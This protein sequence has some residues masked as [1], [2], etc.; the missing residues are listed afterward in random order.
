MI[1]QKELL[2]SLEINSRQTAI[3]YEGKEIS[4]SSLLSD[5]NRITQFLLSKQLEEETVIGV[6]LRDKS[7]LIC[8]II[9]IVNARC[10]FVLLDRS[11]P[12]S[13]MD[14]LIND[15]GLQ[16]VISAKDTHASLATAKLLGRWDYDE[17]QKI[18]Q[19]SDEWAY[20]KAEEGDSLY[21]YFTSG[22]TGTPKGI[23]G[24]NCSLLQFLQWEIDEFGIDGDSR[25]SQFISPYFD[26]FLRDIFV[27]LLAGGTICIPP[28]EED[29]FSSDKIIP[30]IDNSRIS[31][32]HC[33]P[34][35]FRI[36]NNN[37]L[38][39]GNFENLKHVLLSGEKINP[40]E[41]A[42]WYDVFGE[43]TQLANFYGATEATMIR[44]CYKIGPEDVKRSRM[45]IGSPIAATKLLI[46]RQNMEP[47]STLVPGDLYIIS[48]YLTKGYLNLP[49]LTSE[50]FIKIN[51]GTPEETVAYKTGD[52][53]RKLA[54][55]QIELLGREDRQV[56][57]RG[58]R[59]ELDEVEVILMKS[60][61]LQ[62]AVVILHTEEKG[63]ESLVAFLIKKDGGEEK[64][65]LQE[66]ISKYLESHVS[67]YMIP[68]NIVFVEEYPLLPNGK[69]NFK[70][71]LNYLT[72]EKEIV[73]PV[74]GTEEK[75]LSIWKEILGERNISTE[76]SFHKIGGN[77]LSLMSLIARV[78]KEFKIRISLSELFKNPTIQKQAL[79]IQNAT[80]KDES[81]AI[82][83]AV[84]AD[85]YVLS[86]SQKRLFFLYKFDPT[87]LAY[88]MPNVFKLEGELSKEHIQSVFKKLISRH[89]S[90][91]TS[92]EVID[93]EPVQRIAEQVDFEVEC[94]SSNEK[95][96][97]AIIQQ[98][99]RPFDLSSPSLIRVGLIETALNE[100]QLMVDLHHIISDGVSQELL[101]KEFMALYNGGQLPESKLNYKDFATWQQGEAQQKGVVQQSK[102]WHEEFSEEV[103]MLDLPT[104][105]VRPSI[106]SY[107]G[108]SLSFEISK[109]ETSKIESIAEREGAT[110]FMV[111]LSAYYI[112]MAKL[113][114]QEDIVVGTPIAGRHQ[115]ELENMFGMFV[116]TLSLRNHPEGNLSYKAFLS[117]VKSKTLSCLD[118]QD[119]PYEE[120]IE[121]LKVE[122]DTSRNPLFD[123]MFSYQNYKE[124]KLEIPELTLSQLSNDQTIS[125]FD[126]TLFVFEKQGKL[127]L[128]F[129][130][131]T[132]LFKKETVEKLIGYFKKIVSAITTDLNTKISDIEIV[133]DHE[134]TQLLTDFNNTE[135]AFDTELTI[136][137]IFEKTAFEHG[138]KTALAFKGEKLSYAEL[139]E[140]SNQ[141]AHKLKKQLQKEDKFIGI[142]MERSL[143]LIVSML[144]VLKSG[145]AY[146][147][148]DPE[149]PISRIQ[150]IAKDSQLGIIL[151]TPATQKICDQLPE[152]VVSINV[153]S[154][155]LRLEAKVP[156]HHRFSSSNLAYLIYT[157]GSTGTPKGVMV[158]HRNVIN[159]MHGIIERIA[160]GKVNS[161]LSLTTSSFDIFVLESIVPLLNGQKIVLASAEEQK[162]T[163]ALY[164]LIK[165]QKT[166]SIQIT[167]SHLKLLL[168]GSHSDVLDDVKVLMVGGEAFPQGLLK[169]VQAC[170]SGKI[171][172]MYGPTE[173][174]VWSSIKD[175][176]GAESINIGTP[177]ANT[178][179]RI[180]DG[181]RRLQAVGI[182]GELYIGGEGVTQGYW[183]NEE[184][185]RERF[186]KDPVTGEGTIYQT[187]DRARWLPDGNI[188]FLGR[189]DNQVKIS[190]HRIELGE[191]ESE[192]SAHDQIEE[193]VIV[194]KEKGEN[195]FLT[196]YYLSE[197][198]LGV[199]E[200]REFLKDRLPV[201]MLP[202]F[203][204]HLDSFPLTPNGKLDKRALP[205]PEIK[206]GDEFTAPSNETEEKL[207][208]LWSETLAIQKES[209]SVDSSFFE[210]G[211]HSI[212]AIKLIGLIQDS[213]GVNLGL[214]AF[215]KDPSIK[216]ISKKI[217]QGSVGKETL[218]EMSID[219][220]HR[221]DPFPLTDVQQAYLIGR[222]DVFEYGN[223][224]TH[225]YSESFLTELDIDGFNKILQRLIDRHEMLRMVITADGEQRILQEVP[226]YEVK[227]LD[228]KEW[229]E[230]EGEELFYEQRNELSHQVF[231]GEEWPLFDIRVT[232]FRDDT[233]K[234]HYSV[235]ALMID[236]GSSIIL[237]N[238]FAEL[239]R[240]VDVELSPVPI[241]FRDYVQ[242]QVGLRD[243]SLFE[244]SQ[245]YWLS[246]VEEMPFAPDLPLVS[247]EDQQAKPNFE[248]HASHLGKTNWDKLQG[249]AK[250]L[251]IT[252][253][254]LLIG[255]FAEVL[256][257]WSKSSHFS[258]NLTLFNRIPF[259]SDVDKVVGD[260]TSLTLLE[261]DFRS[262]EGFASRLQGIQSR[263][264]EDLEH[265]YF[266]GVEMQRE[267]SRY[268]GHSVIVP[269][270]IT[271]T[272]GL[273]NA[274]DDVSKSQEA[275][276]LDQ[277][278][279]PYSIT[280]TPQVWLDFQLGE[281]KEGLWFIWDSIEGLF[282]AGVLSEMFVAYDQLLKSLVDDEGL[283]DSKSLVLLPSEQQKTRTS[284]N[285]TYTPQVDKRL[286]ELFADQVI[287][288]PDNVAVITNTTQ[289]TYREINTM[290]HVLGGKLR[291]L[292]A[293]P[294]GLV[295]IVMEKGWEQVVASLGILYSGAAYL[296]I[297]AEL[298]EN[299]IMMLLEQ[300]EVDIIVTTSSVA[301]RL[302]FKEDKAVVL[303]E[304]GL[305]KEKVWST[306]NPVQQH[307]DLAYVIFTSG[308]SGMP[309]GV[310]ID[311]QGAVNTVVD[312]NERFGVGPEDRVL[313]IS[314]LSFD[315]SVYDIF[316][317]LG[318]G[319][320]IVIP[321]QDELRSPD[322]WMEYIQKHQI[323]IWNTVPALMQ[324]LVDYNRE[325]AQLPLRLAMLSG[326]WI[327]L[328]LPE[329]IKST[330][331][332]VEVISL[333]GATEASIWSIYYPI[334]EVDSRWKSIPYGKP[335]KNQGFQVLKPDLSHCP[336]YV[337][338]DLYITGIGLA[339][340]YWKDAQKT[341]SSFITHPE[342]GERLY[343]T[344]DL[345]RYTSDGNIEFLGR[346]DNQVKIQGFRIELGEIE[347]QMNSHDQVKEAVVLAKENKGE[348][349]LV[350]YYE[351][352]SEIALSDFKDFLSQVLP[353]YMI[354]S[355]YV[356]LEHFPL[357]PNGK[358]SVKLLPDPEIKARPDY[359]AP[360]NEVHKKLIGIWS[361]VLSI[362][363]E[364]I[365]INRS[366][367]EMGGH[368]LKAME[369]INKIR[370]ELEVEI[371]LKVVFERS[372]IQSISEFI[373]ESEKSDYTAIEK[374]AS[375]AFYP[376]SSAQKRLFF[377]YA[378]DRTS[379]A[380]NGPQTM[381]FNGTLDKDKFNEVFHQLI[382][383]HEGLRTSFELVD[384]E[385]VQKI[386][387]QAFFEIKHI[388]GK[389]EDIQETID[390]FIQPFDLS[391]APLMRVGLIEISPKEHIMMVDT[392]HI[393]T[394]GISQ[395]VLIEDFMKLYNG[396][397]LSGLEIQY[398]DYAEWQ[399]KEEQ[400]KAIASQKDFWQ[401][402]FSKEVE[403]LDLP[404]DFA[405]PTIKSSEGSSISFE[406]SKS[407]TSKIESLAKA[408]GATMFMVMLSVYNILIAKLS[409]QEDIV[410][411]TPIAGRPQ[412]ELENMFGMFINTLSLRNHPKGDLSY[413]VF[414]SLLKSKTL[415]CLDNQD[416]PYEEL[417]EM[418]NVERD[419]SRN[420]LFDIMFSYQN[421]K[422]V[423]FEIPGLTL[424]ELSTDQTI[425]K[426]D[427]TLFVYE[428]QGKLKLDFEYATALFKRET[429]EKFIG[430][431]NSIITTI[432]DDVNVKLSDIE[433]ISANEKQQLLYAFN[434][435]DNDFQPEKTIHQLFAEHVTLQPNAPAV[436]FEGETL[437]YRELDEKSN[438]LAGLLKAEGITS[439]SIVGLMLENSTEMV[440]GILGILKAGG[441][442]LP[443]DIEYP[444]ERKKYL[445]DD[446]RAELLLT[447]EPLKERLEHTIPTLFVKDSEKITDETP[448]IE[449][450]NKLSDL[451]Y[452]IYTSGSTGKP[453]GVMI[454]HGSLV[455]YISWASSYYLN[456]EKLSFPLYSSA[457]FDL[458]VTSI[459]TPLMTGN[460]I[461]IYKDNDQGPLIEQVIKAGEVDIIKLTPSHLKLLR[462]GDLLTA[463]SSKLK[464]LIVGG[465]ELETS[466]ARDVYDKLGGQVAIY[467]EYGPT[468][469]TVGCMIHEFTFEDDFS[470]VPIGHP[471]SNTQI[472]I[473]DKYQKP[474]ASGVE[475]ELYISGAGVA[476]GYLSNK[477]LTQERFLENPFIAG[478][479]MYR[480]GDLAQRLADG[481]ILFR[482]RKDE[483][484]KLRGYRI[485]LGEIEHQL[486]RHQAVKETVVLV[487][488]RGDEGDKYLLAY[489]I[490][491]LGIEISELR[492][493]LSHKIP[494]YM[495]PMH[496]VHLEQWPLTP[497]GKLD[498]KALPDPEMTARPDYVAPSN[499]VQEKLVEIWSRVLSID[500]EIIGINR[501]F[502]ELGGHSLK[503]MKLVNKIREELE[504]EIP[505]KVVFERRDIQGIS[506]FIQEAEKST[507]S[508]I[509]KA[510]SK[511]F[512]PVSSVQK[513]LFFLYE[514]DRSSLAYNGPYTMRF[515]GKLDKDKL[516]KVFRQLI[517]RHESLRTSFEVVNDEPVQKISKKA[518][519]EIKHAKGKEEDIPEIVNEF[520][521]PFDLSKPPLMKV[522]LIEV[523]S[524]EHIM[525]VDTHHIITDGISQGVLIQDFMKL[526]NG[527]SLPELEI[528]YKDYAV[529]QQGE[530][531]QKVIASQKD[532]WVNRFKEETTALELPTDFARPNIKSS[533][534]SAIDFD[535]N[536]S[537]VDQLKLI[538][539]EENATLFM[540]MLAIY[541][542]LL[543]K[544]SAQ[545]G[546]TV[547]VSLAGRRHSDVESMIGMFANA[548]PLR[549][550]MKGDLS[551]KSFLELLKSNTISFF[552]N[553]D[554]PYEQLVDALDLERNTSR[555][556]LFDTLFFYENY[557]GFSLGIPG[558]EIEG[559]DAEHS[560]SKFDLSL[561]IFEADENISLKFEYST[562]LFKKETIDKFIQYFKRIVA[563]VLSDVNVKISDIDLLSA[564][565]RSQLLVDFNDTSVDLPSNKSYIDLFEEQV[566]ITP[567]KVAVNCEGVQITYRELDER[568]T[569]LALSLL[570]THPVSEVAGLFVEPTPEMLIGILGILKSGKAFLPLDPRQPQSRIGDIL[571][572]SACDVIITTDS[573][574]Q[575]LI[576]ERDKLIVDSKKE[577][578]QQKQLDVKVNSDDL[579]YVI[580]TSGST[581]KPKGV[582]IQ[583][584]NLVNYVQS[585]GKRIDLRSED[586]SILT[587]SFV[588]DL[589]YSS[590][591]TP[592]TCGAEIH[593]VD[594]SLY[595]SP[596]ILL[597]YIDKH[598]IT[599]LKLTPSLLRTIVNAANFGMTAL[600]KVKHIVLGGE[601]I[602]L[603]DVEKVQN[604]YE[605]IK[606]LDEYGPTETTVGSIVQ[607]ID[608]IQSLK[609]QPSIGRPI[610]NTK[611]FILDRDQKLIPPGIV[612]E[613]C[614]A[615]AGVGRG[616]LNNQALNQEKFIM[617]SIYPNGNIYKTG[618]LAKWLPDGR[619]AFLGR[620]DNQVKIRGYRI[621]PD[622]IA[623]KLRHHEL[624]KDAA[625]I[626]TQ[627][628]D[629][630]LVAY[631]VSDTRIDKEELQDFLSNQLPDYM[632]PSDFCELDKMPLTSNGKLDIKALP[633]PTNEKSAKS[634]APQ[635]K[636]E[637]L[638]IK[639]WSGILK[640]ENIG[641]TDNFFSIGGDSIKCI[642]ICSKV[643][644]LGYELSIE[645]VITHQTIQ[646]I[647]GRLK[648]LVLDSSQDEVSGKA[649][650]TPIQ[651]WF[652][653][654]QVKNKHHFNQSVIL[655]FH[656]S[657]SRET[658]E[659]I[660]KKLLTHHDALRTVFK[661]EKDK[662]IQQN[663]G[664][665]TPLAVEV[666]DLRDTENPSASL[667]S[668]AN[669]IQSGID[670]IN[671]PLLKLGLFKMNDGDRL[672]IVIHHLVIDG[673]S[674]RILFEDIDN[675]Y[676]QIGK[677]KTMELP[678]KTDSFH[679]WANH[680]QAYAKT[681]YFQE[682][683]SYWNKMLSGKYKSL[684]RDFPEGDN[685]YG[686]RIPS[687]FHLNKE[688][689]SR[690]LSEVHNSFH[691][692][693]NDILLAAFV[694]SINE[695]FGHDNVKIDLEGHGRENIHQ[696]ENVSR[697]VG[698]FTSIYP[699]LLEFGGEDLSNTV[700]IVKETLRH[701]PN[702][703]IDYL[704]KRCG[705]GEKNEKN[706][707]KDSQI[708]FN[709]LGQFDSDINDKSFDVTQELT[710]SNVAYDEVSEYD[711]D[712]SGMISGEELKITLLYSDAQYREETIESFMLFYQKNLIELIDY[713]CA[714]GKEEFTPSD[715]TYKDLS[716]AQV[717]ELSEVHD[718]EDL[719]P[720]SPMQEGM[721]FHSLLDSESEYYFEQVTYSIKGKLDVVAIENSMNSLMERYDILRTT[722]LHEGYDRPIQV[723]L[724]ER[725][726]DFLFI[727]VREECLEK[728]KEEIKKSYQ[729][730]QIA[731]KF[732]LS[733]DVL[734]RLMVL[735]TAEDEF[736]FIWGYHH[737]LMDGWCMSIITSELKNI[738]LAKKSG[739]EISLPQTEPFSRYIQW[740]ESRNKKESLNYWRGY[741]ENY[742]NLISLP[743][744]DQPYLD[745]QPYNLDSEE[746]LI[747]KEVAGGLQRVSEKCSVTV[748]TIIQ[749]AWGIL[750]GRYNNFDD[751]V[752]G[753][754]VSGRPAEL[755]GMEQVVGLF[756]N[757]VPVRI[758]MEPEAEIG[759]LLH[760]VQKTALEG[761][762]YHYN[763]L[764]E[765]QAL[766]KAG[767]NLITCVMVF[768]NYPVADEITNTNTDKKAPED[769]TITDV[770]FYE[771]TNYDMM[772]FV[773]PGD[774]IFIRMDYNTN[775]YAR[776]TIEN[777]LG[778][779]KNIIRQITTNVTLPLKDIVLL[780]D[781][782]RHHQLYDFNDTYLD[783]DRGL[784][785]NSIF[786]KTAAEHGDRTAI[787]F[788]GK[789]LSYSELNERSN[790]LAQ[791]IKN[792]A[793]PND[794]FIGILMERSLEL[795]VSMMAVLKSGHAYVPIDPEYPISRIKHIA[796]DSELGVILMSPSTQQICD[797]LSGNMALIDVTS[798]AVTS[799]PGEPL[800][801][802]F[803][804][805][806]LA[807]LI[808]TSGSTGTPKGV[809]VTHGN[810]VN[811]MHGIIERIALEE[812]HSILSLTTSSFDIFVLESIVP[813]LNGLKIV[814]TSAEEQKDTMALYRL[815]K[816][817]KTDAVQITPS[818]LKLLLSGSQDDVLE[819]VKVLMVGGEAFPQKLLLDIKACYS[820]KIYNMYGP[821]ETTVWS[822]IRDLTKAESVNIGTPIANTSL[823]ILDGHGKLQPLGVSGDLY[824]GGEGVS[825]G[826]W[827]NQPLTQE[828]FILDPITGEGVIYQTGDTARWLPDGN[829]AFLGRKDNQVKVNGHRIEL[830][831][832]ESHLGS[833]EMIKEV[834]AG[835]KQKAGDAYLVAYYQSEEAIEVSKLIGHLQPKLPDY[836]IPNFYIRL[837]EFPLT[838]NGKLDRM[839]LPEPEIESG[840]QFIAPVTD[841]EKKLTEMWADILDVDHELISVNRSFFELGGHSLKSITL[842]N[843]ISIEFGIKILLKDVFT[844]QNIRNLSALITESF[845]SKYI[846][847]PKAAAKPHYSLSQAQ[848]P[849]FF[850]HELDS[851]SLIRNLT[852]TAEVK[853]TLDKEKLSLVFQKLISRHESLRTSFKTMDLQP[854]Q[855]ISEETDFEV[856]HFS[857]EREG[858][859]SVIK[860]FVRPFDISQAPLIRVGLIA[861]DDQTHILMVDVHHLIADGLSIEIL[862]DEFLVLYN[863]SDLPLLKTQYTDFVVWQ[864]SAD[865]QGKLAQ[866]KQFWV[867]EFAEEI[868]PLE[869]PLDY[870][871][872]EG[873]EN[874]G[875]RVEFRMATKKTQGLRQIAESQGATVA[876]VVLSIYN[877]LLSKL[878][879]QED[880]VIG[881]PLSGREQAELE[882]VVGMFAK[883]LPVRSYPKA[884]LS[885]EE[886]LTEVKYKFSSAMDN[887][888]YPFEE[889]AKELNIERNSMR[890]PWYDVMFEYQHYHPSDDL[891]VS[892]LTINQYSG[893]ELLTEQNL[894]LDVTEQED[895]ILLGLSYSE[896]LFKK[897]TVDKFIEYFK[898]IT[899]AILEDPK[900]HIAKID[901][902]EGVERNRLLFEFNGLKRDIDREKVYSVLF[903]EQVEKTP[904]HIA[905]EHNGVVLSYRELHERSIDLASYLASKGA[906]SNAKVGIYMP[907]GIDM[908]VSILATLQV[909]SSYVP[910]DVFYPGKRIEEIVKDSEVAIV[911]TN[912]E[913]IGD[914]DEI[915]ESTASL[916]ILFDINQLPLTK[917]EGGPIQSS[918]GKTDDLAYMIYTSGTTG[919]PKGVMIHQLGMINH[920]YAKIND[921]E[922]GAT[923]VIAQTASPCFDISVWQFLAALMVGGKT[924][925]IDKEKVVYPDSL[926]IEL[927]QGKVS[928]FESVPSLMTSFLDDLPS[929]HDLSLKELRWMIP[930]GEVLSVSLAKK[931]YKYFP[932]IK[933]LNAYGPTE[934]S[935]DV[936]HYV[937]Q[938]PSGGEHVIPIGQPLSNTRI[939]ILNEH[940]GLCPIGVR[941]E[942]CVAGLGVGKGYWRNEE[943]TKEA[944]VPNPLLGELEDPDYAV[945]YKTG[946]I[947][948][949]REDG[950][951]IYVGR[952]DDQLKINGNRV[953]VGEI[954]NRLSLHEDIKEAAVLAKGDGVNKY[955]V[956]YYVSDQQ[957]NQGELRVHLVDQLPDY[958]IPALYERLDKMPLTANGKLNRNALPEPKIRVDENYAKPTTVTEIKLCEIW[959]EV[960]KTE[961]ELISINADFFS[962]GGN[963]L[964]SISL[965]GKIHRKLNVKISLRDFFEKPTVR[966]TA[967]YIDTISWLTDEN[968]DDGKAKGKIEISI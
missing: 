606:F 16:Y 849:L 60:G 875:A 663:A 711:W 556:P 942:L 423:T 893:K 447:T 686:K 509:E 243:S 612:G 427:M 955:L 766:S 220:E 416:Y 102:F 181:H 581:G 841:I 751:V 96:A 191:I 813:L 524:E 165:G 353:S 218:P 774:E 91:R 646:K 257:R 268:H 909:G 740:L 412:S 154:E 424:S 782:E 601:A 789:S 226:L 125:K 633:E 25:F 859:N 767:N 735:Q 110:M 790:Q 92:F 723:V 759:D 722:F 678:A 553:Q 577:L 667:L 539:K 296:P 810:V 913:H 670:L 665:N 241:S 744:I 668:I 611:V 943:K 128:D 97:P 379:L 458:T 569:D 854:V 796:E 877:I 277:M 595:L 252:P 305:K 298:P 863:G 15:L 31:T 295:G 968:S 560:V 681:E 222:K 651:E 703:G 474:I 660:F 64:A 371:P 247:A 492:D 217:L 3:E 795:L 38:T 410:I 645:D 619:I 480:T 717:D 484:V 235:D 477:A 951:I 407:H 80:K 580:Y 794:K 957:I 960:L 227:V 627:E 390:A 175:L 460:K 93:G 905:V 88:N 45:P 453:K 825:Q 578:T 591:F 658:I 866:Q 521:Q 534:G 280:Q 546:V 183:G 318:A 725:K 398:K 212:L 67:A 714:Y 575:K 55:G 12:S 106:K 281:D 233:Y 352:G 322:R 490:S 173:T 613:L 51:E 19:S 623:A 417:I 100:H 554:Y 739:V 58:I 374:V 836:M 493:F 746:L 107:A 934:A 172:N 152:D 188:E 216:A 587:S 661:E 462:E 53:A 708:I 245:K 440:I 647:A 690:L 85:H 463:N 147:P 641:T 501:S 129:E 481:T 773:V 922:I 682:A 724:K 784:T 930:T 527:E 283:W 411:G 514:L 867:N 372:D 901:I 271:S 319:G 959:S 547:G 441:A 57:L 334:E 850:Q 20:P 133:S 533:E 278:Q 679:S 640:S 937:V 108:S 626:V 78:N 887:Q 395:G 949:Y 396:E 87:S 538:A 860:D 63:Q 819:G 597:E 557:Q 815:I 624:I 902:V 326:D 558:L 807:Y 752:F 432:L 620:V 428:K 392:H 760:T 495:L 953:E 385:P 671:G 917:V 933:L 50:R 846:S 171:Y 446:S 874:R 76:D 39:S 869:V 716:V 317:V 204:V 73:L 231:S 194:V 967:E 589:G 598:D 6:D 180:L 308:S 632:V 215:F 489:Y 328:S 340:G 297:G 459:F 868:V 35:L 858:V 66:A 771:P 750:L 157:S 304:E 855:V 381:R 572:D 48:N 7:N 414:L 95:N 408:E 936:T 426:F 255:C 33:V 573:L 530:E 239:S 135:L 946:D 710:G 429:V 842:V 838:N 176:T 354:P 316:G 421:Y 290:S 461:V 267:M 155:E 46:A 189:T 544:L 140:R 221:F 513:R 344:G 223:V 240:D 430:Y 800:N 9:G 40:S 294:N 839:A 832:I 251:G 311:H 891:G 890:N 928:I 948:Y 119:Y 583:H 964:L 178:T 113:S 761:D 961:S 947:G 742:N 473:L 470:S 898:Q 42:N 126:L 715:F 889:L 445:L 879:R 884:Q 61:L 824:I 336:D 906:G 954:E 576:F 706:T 1:F 394:D 630:K 732:D 269:V 90:L 122:R 910:I 182:A 299:R 54:G 341:Q 873:T 389:E 528:H 59:I 338:G 664:T 466:L 134:K 695:K 603:G 208:A 261:M 132:A 323:T 498:K 549:N 808:Y 262:K 273:D 853:G 602:V 94:F 237:R 662:F 376:V 872:P 677:N 103:E 313:A 754:V 726:I 242:S 523:A 699:V 367:F 656:E 892:D 536:V 360:S 391:K 833:H 512:Y 238:E 610:S 488:E 737:I 259:H 361:R 609:A 694:L 260:F 232:K 965:I 65:G 605:T 17:I 636:E 865:Y 831:E 158:T 696:G 657:V 734:M 345:G 797:Q 543:S 542:I 293:V 926:F 72:P 109:E 482:G 434:T 301:E 439:E 787:V 22:S 952:K 791:H 496:Y 448:E 486:A 550:Q 923:D 5:A 365:G 563:A 684:K 476:R 483:Q 71:L 309:K 433:M 331:R 629:K 435:V 811:F 654:G 422:E 914:F 895:E 604:T 276:E 114:N 244:K 704:L 26:A 384:D 697:T 709:Y 47:C 286:H 638:L 83:L 141:L 332:G 115:P 190:G 455:N 285:A 653:N 409:N 179:I 310:M 206:V 564:K 803:S 691:T 177:L 881:I 666:H 919:K 29:F 151:I 648:K 355:Y 342:T 32:I 639:V 707:N 783:F 478:A 541:N 27:P 848:I 871:R 195:K 142:L 330:N 324:M 738:Y 199:S 816:D 404:T 160:F 438:Q 219:L 748:N 582:K 266:S 69:I 687:S 162:D 101:I 932:D 793:Q 702:N 506:K 236:A 608:D 444:E 274:S 939:F 698:W 403:T 599:Y 279:E 383:R 775:I 300:G 607:D 504:V 491:E 49:E 886:F 634:V 880:I 170:Y 164:K 229:P 500:E 211:G 519:F 348:K 593:L 202:S 258:L 680:L 451:C 28:D 966:S 894:S 826:Y 499:E 370:E 515:N 248:R 203:Y 924:Y 327:P 820:G 52:K 780:S 363:E 185:T 730:I 479:K 420:P 552:D 920:L 925:I 896:V 117:S 562:A 377:L 431:F 529:W 193:A 676:Q 104:D 817:Q 762:K 41:L 249:K 436:S 210:L 753:S 437:T 18:E 387:R 79:Y 743:R 618:D 741:V 764:S 888:S 908:L 505:L 882:E 526:Y 265:K 625:I 120:L 507:Y 516:S 34:S 124:T 584:C 68:S 14:H 518:F 778:H 373:Q 487:K 302:T 138:D 43:R 594:R 956:A 950:N 351:S 349:Y 442:Y 89:E 400:Q 62:N 23:V 382:A 24:K 835:V 287:D 727:D 36:I 264:W 224:G 758:K 472:Y 834:V 225:M 963:S 945:L 840:E 729:S 292:G 798:E 37:S 823:R 921:L 870:E 548:L 452:V 779:L 386:S 99:I 915:F 590:I 375:K 786:E 805:A 70:G 788:Q 579:A 814:L 847:I 184:L 673:V 571:D 962:L 358:V 674:W 174:T 830:G 728:S 574:S 785:I 545:E 497:N 198:D 827:G 201:Y 123:V 343:K 116:N 755:E 121:A 757:T 911:I 402:E 642:L 112:L 339:K 467:N 904:D 288:T 916:E 586:K 98:F 628:E 75:I 234:I 918:L 643:R 592:L 720:L 161:I 769:F 405:R 380:Y 622:E 596:E 631:Y 555:N 712:I 502:F 517:A 2:K 876:M 82:S 777:A 364:I 802:N 10:V 801:Q 270:V 289:F 282:P 368:S 765:I 600:D 958:M 692:Q 397:S 531:Q 167:P 650:L 718:M 570:E 329:G 649:P 637:E 675:L 511:A 443:I 11:L 897:E 683:N 275:Y 168:S 356:H 454:E 672:L 111:M 425:S 471:I 263:L 616:Y 333:G 503:A 822:T 186:V 652:F 510:G 669:T 457:S 74:N 137:S 851:S 196:A 559:V 312:I 806:N 77:S 143:E 192:L 944:F 464:K 30:W 540:A 551:F 209:I 900:T 828:K 844:H 359:V 469:A 86:S 105:F 415:S 861:L 315:L 617:S 291:S 303:V 568:S 127:K 200:L 401:E 450:T 852:Y 335:L 413:K 366:F 878:A 614:I 314:S 150:H 418:L 187:G 929:D 406:I 272:L 700:K 912:A 845:G 931:W 940:L 13:R 635:S 721:L 565:E 347:Y 346:E 4:Y 207:V 84:K 131:A 468:E 139:N 214:P 792:Q 818:H 337:P 864:E 449:N 148:I 146:V 659:G 130:Y 485:E 325:K 781:Q 705:V 321:D 21:I 588:F 44:S 615:G 772:I 799:E 862:K 230:K 456:G 378:L 809:M 899:D 621:E 494:D 144:G 508:T 250:S 935:D 585:L 8:S 156:L 350:A 284:V 393:I 693:I 520:V 763:P 475:G 655:N 561:I 357:T 56:K 756:I 768:E 770:Q 163:K 733:R 749:C 857:S 136:N 320:A 254:I 256:N 525:M 776:E 159:F 821:T 307:S 689:T 153:R 883:V 205:D 856:I 213:F 166:D 419:I 253:T 169:D 228:L 903:K 537:E 532:F 685:I 362:D 197:K 535:L 118:N 145:C 644:T 941:G 804:S 567:N 731:E 927:R 713:C 522:G 745:D 306:L 688:V 829:I 465:E 719:Y 837:N 885:F 369:L 736:E 747:S 149:Y 907:R 566:K 388:K 938:P 701:V 246:R 843:K 812:A 399:Q 81:G